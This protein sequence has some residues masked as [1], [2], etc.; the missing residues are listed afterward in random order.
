MSD[1]ASAVMIRVLVQGMRELGL[2]PGDVAPPGDAARVGLQFK[3]DVV[4]SA[5]AQGGL[6]CL[7]LLGRGLHRFPHDPTHRALS[8]ARDAPDL[9]DRWRRLE[10]YI[11]SRHRCEVRGSGPGWARLHHVVLSGAP[12]P[13]PAEDLVVAGVLAAL[14]EAIGLSHVQ[15][16][17]DQVPIY[18]QVDAAGLVRAVQRSATALWDFRWAS[19]ASR[20]VAGDPSDPLVAV[21]ATDVR[22]PDAVASAFKRLAADLTRSISLPQL[23]DELGLAPR[24]LQ[25]QLGTAGLSFSKVLAE[26]RCRAGSWRLLHT[27]EPIAEIGFLCG[28]ADQPHFTR[29][30]QRRV[31]MPPA[32]YR[33]AFRLRV[34]SGIVGPAR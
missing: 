4:A 27:E 19:Q 1:F 26:A 6:T 13:L 31:G 14:L 2:D 12:A 23:A 25:R 22:W 11:H 34:S 16:E 32:A 17:I 9:F 5:I 21:L 18:P 29:E 28:Y 3:R 8:L 20:S 33:E 10:R 7:P 30:M 15:V 24:T